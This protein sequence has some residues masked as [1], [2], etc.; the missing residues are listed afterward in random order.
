MRKATLV[1]VT[2]ALVAGAAHGSRF[3]DATGV[4]YQADGGKPGDAADDCAG[5]E[6][7]LTLERPY[8]GLLAAG[9]DDVDHI[10]V[11]FG[12]QDLGRIFRVVL[13]A[14]HV[15]SDL[16]RLFLQ[17]LGP[18]CRNGVHLVEP[19]RPDEWAFFVDQP[20]LYD[21]AVHIQGAKLA[22]GG[23]TGIQS[24]HPMCFT[25]T[26]AGYSVELQG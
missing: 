18:D 16:D 6:P 20:G 17:V 2:L 4:T 25:P 7:G 1:I 15:E 14:D 3:E 22:P 5:R 23:A 13:R 24:C 12:E 9:D 19:P 10:G 11:A 8:Q 21:V 26:A